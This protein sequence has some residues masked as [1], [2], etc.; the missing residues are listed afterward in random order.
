MTIVVIYTMM[1]KPATR[2]VACATL[3]PAPFSREPRLLALFRLPLSQPD[4]WT[5]AVLV[6]EF[7]AGPL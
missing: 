6:D 3:Q 4:P 2:S 7:H 1:V 5:T